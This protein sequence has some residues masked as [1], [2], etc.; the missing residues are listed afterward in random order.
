MSKVFDA[1]VDVDVDVLH[2]A[3]FVL[4]VLLRMI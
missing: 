4:F 3:S 1:N 2:R